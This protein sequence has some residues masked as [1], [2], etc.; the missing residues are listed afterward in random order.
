MYNTHI[1]NITPSIPNDIYR[2]MRRYREINWSEV[3][4]QAIIERLFRIK[5]S[6]DG[7]TREELAMFLE[8]KGIEI[9]KVE[10]LAEKELALLS[11][12]KERERVTM[13]R[14]KESEGR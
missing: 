7:L 10:L 5:A 9:P 14:L 12:I 13:K 4:R 8:I 2:L 6:R 11:R 1:T 3:A